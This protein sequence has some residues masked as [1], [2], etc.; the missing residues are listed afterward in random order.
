MSASGNLRGQRNRELTSRAEFELVFARSRRVVA[1]KHG[2]DYCM[3]SMA[4]WL[5]SH[6]RVLSWLSKGWMFER[7]RLPLGDVV[8]ERCDDALF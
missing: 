3:L 5:I 6:S 7:L 8:Y 4:G 2:S 1:H